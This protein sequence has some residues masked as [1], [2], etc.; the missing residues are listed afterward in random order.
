M[1]KPLGIYGSKP[2]IVRLLRSLNAVN[3]DVCVIFL[4]F[5][6]MLDDQ[7]LSSRLLLVPTEPGGSKPTLSPGL[8]VLAA[9]Q[10]DPNQERHYVIYWP[11]DTTWNDSAAASV[12]RN[13]VTFMRWVLV[14]DHIL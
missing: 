13:R 3:E 5:R 12:C 14:D 11:E 4:Y 1:I 2:E 10:V 7:I 8:Y 9:G 6:V